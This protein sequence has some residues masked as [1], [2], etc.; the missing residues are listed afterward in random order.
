MEAKKKIL[1]VNESLTLAGGEK[2]LIAL[3]NNLNPELYDIDLQLFRYGGALD[4][5]IPDHV[6]VL[7][8]FDYSL[9]AQNSWKQNLTSAIKGKGWQFLKSK[10]SYSINIRKGT[11]NHPEKAQLYWEAVHRSIPE[12]QEQYDIAI[13]YAQGIPTF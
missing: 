6:N 4:V 13:A 7:P 11:F 12:S 8:P 3:L 1:F 9:Y 2:S 5:F 10:L